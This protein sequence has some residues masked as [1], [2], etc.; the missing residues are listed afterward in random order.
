[1][2]SILTRPSG[3]GAAPAPSGGYVPP[4]DWLE[5]PSITA[6][7]NKFAGVVAEGGGA[8]S[9]STGGI[10]GQ[11]GEYATSNDGLGCPISVCGGGGA[12]PGSANTSN[13]AGFRPNSTSARGGVT[14]S[15][16]GNGSGGNS[17]LALGGQAQADTVAG[18]AGTRGSGGSGASG[19]ASGAGGDGVIIIV[20]Y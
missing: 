10:G 18:V 5:L 17:V 3:G 12:N 16:S 6:G 20:E 15:A 9:T 1:M 11:V 2:P 13:A 8:P 14:N 4:S 7:E 19:A